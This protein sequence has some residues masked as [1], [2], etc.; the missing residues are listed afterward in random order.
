M[1]QETRGLWAHSRKGIEN[2]GRA[3]GARV[4]R[5]SSAG[6]ERPQQSVSLR[7]VNTGLTIG[8]VSSSLNA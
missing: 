8:R 4:R 3:D 2:P 6:V 1:T 7:G 5:G